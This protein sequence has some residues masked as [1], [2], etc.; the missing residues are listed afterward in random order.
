MLY[1]KQVYNLCT[2]TW[3]LMRHIDDDVAVN[4]STLMYIHQ[5]SSEAFK[6]SAAMI[7]FCWPGK[8]G[9][10]QPYPGNMY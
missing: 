10:E 8:F 7:S 2:Q 3:T 5:L 6:G 9:G 4:Q 1:V